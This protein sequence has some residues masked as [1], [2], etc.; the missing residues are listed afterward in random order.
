MSKECGGLNMIDLYT[1]QASFYLSW[2]NK[3]LGETQYTWKTIPRINFIPVGGLS[4]FKSSV[5]KNEFKG[6]K[7]IKSNFWKT[8][9]FC[10]IKHNNKDPSQ[11]ICDINDPIF[12]NT[13]IRFKKRP[14]FIEG[15]ISRSLLFIKDFL[16]D[17]QMINFREFAQGMEH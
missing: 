9:L 16:S 1:L 17:W 6:E 8:F 14:L 7:L 4:V 15:C 3:L 10:W 13:Y 12:N 2:A 11:P 5:K